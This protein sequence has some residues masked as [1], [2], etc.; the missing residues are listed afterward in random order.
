VTSM[1][2]MFKNAVAFNQDIGAWTTSLVSNMKGMF[3]SAVHFNQNIGSWDVSNVTNMSY[4][5]KFAESFN[6][7]IGSWDM[8]RVTNL[9]SIFYDAVSFD[10]GLRSW[11]V[12][13]VTW[14]TRFYSYQTLR[15]REVSSNEFKIQLL[16]RSLNVLNDVDDEHVLCCMLNIHLSG[17]KVSEEKFGSNGHWR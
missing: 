14:T 15:N 11:D 16:M 6:Q 3:C 12:S 7:D 5:F 4:M 10:H 9:E 1:M 8:S 17:S 2:D 13:N